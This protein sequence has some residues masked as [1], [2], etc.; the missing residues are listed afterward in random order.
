VIPSLPTGEAL[1]LDSN[2]SNSIRGFPHDDA[3][4]FSSTFGHD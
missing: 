2:D 4:L 3:N 1:S